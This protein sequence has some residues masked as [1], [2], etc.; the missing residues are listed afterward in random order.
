MAFEFGVQVF[1]I[2]VSCVLKMLIFNSSVPVFA[3]DVREI[4]H[5]HSNEKIEHDVVCEN[6]DRGEEKVGSSTIRRAVRHYKLHWKNAS[7]PNGAR[8]LPKVSQHHADSD[9]MS[10]APDMP[11]FSLD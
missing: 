7:Q 3:L 11:E 9:G 8:S 1:H 5:D 2:F 4:V 6:Q 10:R